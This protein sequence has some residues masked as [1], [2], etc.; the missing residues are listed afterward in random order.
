MSQSTAQ[1]GQAGG[2]GIAAYGNIIQ[3]QMT[4]QTLDA[5]ANLQESQASEAEQAGGYNASRAMLLANQKIGQI[6]GAYGASGVSQTSG[7][8]QDVLGASA[9]SAEL[10]RL[11]ILHGADIK[12]I[13]YNNQASLD[14]YGAQSAIYGGNWKAAGSLE[15]GAMSAA[16]AG[17]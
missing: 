4:A 5:Q 3:G 14:R 9:A 8:V 10:D 17:A 11:N 6:K 2:G 16:E 15:Q 1:A 13:N 7:S 12:A